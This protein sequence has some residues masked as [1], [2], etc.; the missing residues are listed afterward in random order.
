MKNDKGLILEE[1]INEVNMSPSALRA[2]VEKIPNAKA[3]LEFELIV[4]NLDEEEDDDYDPYEDFDSEPDYDQD[5]HISTRSW[6]SLAG[7][8]MQFCRGDHNSRRYVQRAI[9]L[10]REAWHEYL[11]GAMWDSYVNDNIQDFIDK[12]YGRDYAN[13]AELFSELDAIDPYESFKAEYYKTWLEN[14]EDD[15]NIDDYLEEFLRDTYTG[16]MMGNLASDSNL[17]LSWPHWT[18]PDYDG[19]RTRATVNVGDF[20][21]A[22]GIKTIKSGG[23]HSITKPDDAYVIEPDSSLSP[24]RGKGGEGLEFVSPPL[25]IPTMIDQINKVKAWAK[26]GN[27]Y[28]NDKTGLHMNI[29]IPGY[30]LDKLDFVKLALFLGDKYILEK[31]GRL[32]NSYAKSAFDQIASFIKQ[33]PGKANKAV[34][35]MRQNLNTVA[36]KLIHNGYTDKFTS[37]NTKDN[38]VEFR[39]PGG[40]WIDMDTDEVVNT[41][42]RVVYAM[43]IALH[44]EMERKEYQKKFAK[45]L[46]ADKKDETDTIKY[47]TA[48]ATG[49][50][51]R[52]A[53]VSY[54]KN[55]QSKRDFAKKAT[56][57]RPQDGD[58]RTAASDNETHVDYEGSDA[59]V[60]KIISRM[61]GQELQSFSVSPRMTYSD[62][63]DIAE[64]MVRQSGRS[65]ELVALQDTRP[66]GEVSD[67]LT[68][69]EIRSTTSTPQYTIVNPANG[70]E[71]TTLNATSLYDAIQNTR[72]WASENNID[73]ASI[74]IRRT[75]NNTVW[76]IQGELIRTAA[77][78]QPSPTPMFV[79]RMQ[80]NGAAISQFRASD[81]NQARETANRLAREYGYGNSE[82]FLTLANDDTIAPISGVGSQTTQQFEI[83]ADGEVVHRFSANS[84]P[85]AYRYATQWASNRGLQPGDW[86]WRTVGGAA[87]QPQPQR[88]YSQFEIDRGYDIMGN[89]IP[90]N[91]T[92]TSSNITATNGARYQIIARGGVMHEFNAASPRGAERYAESWSREHLGD[93]SY[94]VQLAPRSESIEESILNEINMSPTSLEK[95]ANTPFAKSMKVGFET[96]MYIP[97]LGGDEDGGDEEEDLDADESFPRDASYRDRTRDVVE[98]FSGGNGI[99][100]RRE[101]NTALEELSEA[102]LE[103]ETEQFVEYKE[104][105]DYKDELLSQLGVE[106]IADASERD[107]ENA[108]ETVREEYLN[109][110]S[111]YNWR[112]FLNDEDISTMYDFMRWTNRSSPSITLYWPHMTYTRG[113]PTVD[114]D[115]VVEDFKRTTGYKAKSSSGYHGASRDETTWI[116]EP[117]SSLDNPEDDGDG[118]GGIELVSPPMNLEDGLAALEN[119][120]DWAKSKGYYTNRTTGFHIGVSIPNQTMENIDHLKV[121]MLLGDEYVLKAFNR[122]G[123]RWTKSSFDQ[124]KRE[125]RGR[126]AKKNVPLILDK[127]RSGLEDI[128]KAEINKLLVPRGDRYVSVNIKP[129]YIEFR[130][131]GGNYF[132]QYEEIRKTMLRYVRVIGAAADSEDAKQ[133]YQKKLYKFVSAGI[134]EKDNTMQL[135]ARYTAGNL[136]KDTL[137]KELRN[138]QERRK[139]VAPLGSGPVDGFLEDAD[140]EQL[141]KINGSN[142]YE[143]IELAVKF[144]NARQIP[145][146]DVNLRYPGYSL[147]RVQY[148]ST[149]PNEM[150]SKTLVFIPGVELYTT[151]QSEIVKMVIPVAEKHWGVSGLRADR[152]GVNVLDE[153]SLQYLRDVMMRITT[154]GEDRAPSLPPTAQSTGAAPGNNQTAQRYVIKYTDNGEDVHRFGAPTPQQAIELANQFQ[155]AYSTV[156][157]WGGTIGRV[158][159]IAL[160]TIA[161]NTDEQELFYMGPGEAIV[162][163]PADEPTPASRPSIANPGGSGSYALFLSNGSQVSAESQFGSYQDALRHFTPL[164]NDS[165]FTGWSVKQ[166]S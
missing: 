52:T 126:N 165:G 2:A 108:E 119:V 146:S 150:D 137:I 162:N 27:A 73:V 31:F 100:T 14:I 49:N 153:Y 3:G 132:E 71:L 5:E 84:Q 63:Y 144:A 82:W 38:R 6:D 64:R 45:L 65:F 103:Y 138:A 15:D 68:R 56:A 117:D 80:S 155:R 70:Q 149:N 110:E 122:A 152:Y 48:F 140:G 160:Y 36:S 89:A 118:D 21:R 17:G 158:R 143:M 125:V 29:S 145:L 41:L 43:N 40:N 4:T 44:P 22:V 161:P 35:A 34:D 33:N 26:D 112:K 93:E 58:I 79:I 62:V 95:F 57:D 51:P 92:A 46:T 94:E 16:D 124:A 166:I 141:V 28:T 76:S 147:I 81:E 30:K 105:T 74:G 9:D 54:I 148:Y 77:P 104:T 154:R 96:E 23:Y 121:I 18:E 86:N 25:D 129:N 123:S 59:I 90:P 142:P 24:T 116:F 101:I 98:F 91:A 102:F 39:S 85:S 50:M 12:R 53:L 156:M 42:L 164:A 97:G 133:E 32:G 111:D 139:P 87:Q 128:A 10:M 47:F 88:Q 136:D 131:A 159:G 114:I 55:A 163:Q 107:L 115:D 106:D 109:N 8:V 120:F 69:S 61:T 19:G 13:Q 99:N 7:D 134:G 151:Y 20:R 135:F 75:D 130:S 11:D 67:I 72:R 78:A 37:I 157:R 127:M 60:F 83:L 66:N 113:D 1:I